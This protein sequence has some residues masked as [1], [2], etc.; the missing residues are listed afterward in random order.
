WVLSYSNQSAQQVPMLHDVAEKEYAVIPPT[1]PQRR[2]SETMWS[3][4]M[5]PTMRSGD[6]P[7]WSQR[8]LVSAVSGLAAGEPAGSVKAPRAARLAAGRD[9]LRVEMRPVM[10]SL[11]RQPG[12]GCRRECT[13]DRNPVK[14]NPTSPGT[15]LARRDGGRW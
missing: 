8:L 11:C 9:R 1:V 5:S 4:L 15:V 12:A 6:S 10:G 14:G 2:T 7:A 3:P 13:P